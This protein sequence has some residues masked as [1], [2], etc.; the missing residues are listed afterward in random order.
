MLILLN[1][2][3]NK[4]VQTIVKENQDIVKIFYATNSVQEAKKSLRT[5][6]LKDMRKEALVYYHYF[7]DSKDTF[8]SLRW[9]EYASIRLLDYLDNDGLVLKDQNLRGAGVVSEPITM[10]Y[11]V[12]VNNKTAS[13]SFLF[14]M[15]YLLRQYQ[16]ILKQQTPS[17][18]MLLEWMQRH[19]TGLD[20][21][22]I[23][24]RE[25]NKKRI[26]TKIVHNID[27]GKVNRVHHK[28]FSSN[29]SFKQKY[30]LIEEMWNTKEFHMQF[31][32]RDPEIL[33]EMLDYSIDNETMQTLRDAK[34]KGIPIFANPYYTSLLLVNPPSKY[35]YA[36][37]PI[38]DY[39]F[40]SKALVDEFGS[41]VAWEKEDII[42]AG[43]P[44]AA[45]WILPEGG[46]IHRRYPEVAIFIP[47][48]TGRA[49][50]GLCVSCQR[51]YGFQK[52]EFNFDLKQ[53]EPKQS[54]ST[55]LPKQLKYFEEDSQLRDILI[56]GGDALMNTDRQLKHLLDEVYLMS[57]RKYKANKN[58]D[59][60][61]AHMSRI[62][63]GSR[64]LV[65]IPQ[66][67]T[68]SLIKIL[69]EFKERAS[70]I[71]FNQFIIQTHFE[72]AIEI[73]LEVKEAVEKILSA[74]WIVTN[75]EVFIPAV[76]SRGHSIKLRKALNDIGILP[77]YTFSV[78][79]FK[80]N[81][82]NFTNNARTV[83]E[84]KEEKYIGLYDEE[85]DIEIAK[86]PSESINLIK[87][88]N[89]LRE[90]LDIPFLATDR[91]VMNLPAV[92][93]SLSFRTIG[94]LN[95]GRRILEFD[96]DKNRQHSPIIDKLGKIKIIESKSIRDYLKQIESYG[97]NLAEYLSIWGYSISQTEERTSI[98]QYSKYDYKV[99]SNF[100]NFDDSKL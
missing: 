23:K 53:L 18:S 22:L 36:D 9:Q 46:C 82:A 50:G 10:L 93:K 19:P 64:L 73:T 27:L 35:K 28:L 100:T 44:N 83:Q 76:S 66:R 94:I 26:I 37:Q 16:G 41:I 63:L 99:S 80:E 56:T 78:K 57:E 38:R 32:F 91:N 7:S 48:T 79:G 5:Y 42:K 87:N 47:K 72:S 71:G 51:M 14:D 1:S 17:K 30:A 29:M 43:K 21:K 3:T 31:A 15:L 45:G 24:M 2:N 84:I 54:W 33:N 74:G 49:C 98:Y 40:T 96:H 89:T 95:D 12:I 86:L 88:L 52:K 90:K 20:T 39:L 62:R 81:S 77:Y 68:D 61:Y 34:A 8:E 13:E 4:I 60:K 67:I 75:Q 55:E 25:L 58:R 92:G 97:E 11:N 85:T 59:K 65:F 70:K 69:K 6:I